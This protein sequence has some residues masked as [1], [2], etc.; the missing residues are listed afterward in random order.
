MCVFVVFVA[1]EEFF[2]IAELYSRIGVEL[3]PSTE[4]ARFCVLDAFA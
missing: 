4:K 1:P 3:E 2:R